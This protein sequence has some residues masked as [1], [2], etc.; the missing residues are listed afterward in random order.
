[1]IALLAIAVFVSFT[2]LDYAD[3][4]H[5]IAVNELRA[6]AASAY[7]VVMLL[8]G[9]LGTWAALDVGGWLLIPAALGLVCGT[10]VAIR[11]AQKSTSSKAN[12]QTVDHME[13]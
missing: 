5:K 4:L 11:R 8:L 6:N 1:V 3:T 2:L 12:L 7:S 10:Q 9:M 13:H